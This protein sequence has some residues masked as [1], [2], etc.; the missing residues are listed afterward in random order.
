RLYNTYTDASNYERG[1]LR[2]SSNV[3]EVFADNAGTGLAR[4]IRLNP[5]VASG[6]WAYRF[7]AATGTLAF[8]FGG[9]QKGSVAVAGG[10]TDLSLTAGAGGAVNA[11]PNGTLA[12]VYQSAGHHVPANDNTVDVGASGTKVR[13]VYAYQLAYRSGSADPTTS[14]I[15]SGGAMVW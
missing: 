6:G 14:D 7:D 13:T 9:V 11:Q 5:N 10:G 8:E 3:L 12:W 15:A 2:W 1:G 4:N